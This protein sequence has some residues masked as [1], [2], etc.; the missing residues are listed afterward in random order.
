MLIENNIK[1]KIS[2]IFSLFLIIFFLGYIFNLFREESKAS[3]K[4]NL[5]A[6]KLLPQYKL[7]PGDKLLI[8]V[9]GYDEYNSE[10]VILPDGTI[11]VRRIGSINVNGITLKEAKKQ[12]SKSYS[13]IFRD[14]ILY[15]DL[16]KTRPIRVAVSGEVNRP[17][18]Y[19]IDVKGENKLVNKD[20]GE[21]TLIKTNGWPTLVDAIQK[22][23]GV[24]NKGDLRNVNLIRK[25]NSNTKMEIIEVNYWETLKNGT[26]I[27]NYYIYDGD[28]IRVHQIERREDNEL[29][30][31]ASS[32]F[33]PNTIT[34]NVIGEVKNPGLQTIKTNSPLSQAILNAGGITNKSNKNK[35]ALIRLNANGTITKSISSFEMAKDIDNLKN[36]SLIDGDIIIVEKNTWAKNSERIKTL[37]EPISELVTPLTIYKVFA[38]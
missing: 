10:V 20:G 37:V 6:S 18:I 24:T 9:F 16:V 25:N 14:P 13:K 26:P 28:S 35:I 8:R 5:S 30:T 32:S 27:K 31:I 29:F 3:I 11:N 15:L 4:E 19:S 33:S 22:A 1:V 36:P 34:I 17:G 38:D 23:G 2:K 21:Q 7:G 12:L